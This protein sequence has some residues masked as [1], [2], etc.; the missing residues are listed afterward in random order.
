[1]IFETPG[2][3]P[4]VAAVLIVALASSRAE[5]KPAAKSG[6]AEATTPAPKKTGL[7]FHG[8]AT[9]VDAAPLR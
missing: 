9:A 7:P 2:H 3:S 1:V 6:S 4:D 8:K 5:D